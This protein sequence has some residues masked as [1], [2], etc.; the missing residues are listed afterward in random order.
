MGQVYGAAASDD[1]VAAIV[2]DVGRIT[3]GGDGDGGGDGRS[4]TDALITG[5]VDV[6]ASEQDVVPRASIAR[7]VVAIDFG[8]G[9]DRVEQVGLVTIF[10]VVVVDDLVVGSGYQADGRADVTSL[11][12][13][14]VGVIIDGEERSPDVLFV[15]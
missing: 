6:V 11:Q 5:Q 8:G 10:P 7:V 3:G 1:A 13:I 4:P 12:V 9:L 2:A 14:G 15:T